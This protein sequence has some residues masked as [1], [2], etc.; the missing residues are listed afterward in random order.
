MATYSTIKDL[1]AHTAIAATDHIEIQADAETTTK[2]TTPLLMK[3]YVLGGAVVGGNVNGNDIL[4]RTGTQTGIT[5]KGFVSPTIATPAI[6]G[7]AALTTDSTEL[8]LLDG[9][10]AQ[11][12]ELNILDGATLSTAE[13][14]VLDGIPAG[15]TATEL[16]YVDGVTSPIQTQLNLK[17]TASILDAITFD[18]DFSLGAGVTN[19][20]YSEATILTYIAGLGTGKVILMTPQ[21][22]VFEYTGANEQTDITHTALIVA[23]QQTDIGQTHLTQ[24]EIK[25]LTEAKNYHVSMVVHVQTAA[26]T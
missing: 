17:R 11:A 4:T 2:R 8:N 21:V 1:S 15:L 23:T 9:L 26:T 18:D 3:A 7:G 10:T 20:V 16:G 24:V 25:N 13:L 14:N 5:G 22:K 12:S 19:K 6:N